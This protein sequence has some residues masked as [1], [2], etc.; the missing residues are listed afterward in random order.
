MM[1][2][3]IAGDLLPWSNNANLFKK[4]DAKTLFGN[5]VCQLFATAD[6]SILN[7]E[8]PLTDA[9][10]KQQKIGPVIKADK[11]TIKGLQALKVKAVALANNH[12]TDYLQKGID[13]TIAVLKSAGIDY[14][15]VI[16]TNNPN[17]C[18]YLSVMIGLKRVCIY[19]VSETF[20]NR[21]T[22][23][24]SGANVYDEWI[25]LNEIKELKQRH[26]FL[27]VIYHGGAE[28][29]QYPTPQT[30]TRFHRMANCGADFITAQHTHCIGCEEWY[31]GS[32]LLYGQGNF[33][34][35]KQSEGKMKTEGL[36]MELVFNDEGGV[37][38]KK[39]HVQ[40]TKQAC[41]SYSTDQTLSS[42]YERCK[43][44]DNSDLIIE[45]YKELKPD[46]IIESYLLAYKG[47]YYIWN[48]F[49]KFL[50]KRIWRNLF[51][52][53]SYSQIMRNLFVQTSDRACE[54]VYYIWQK[55]LSKN[56]KK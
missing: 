6:Y 22:N 9:T 8:G 33:L 11:E 15:G 28:Y 30:R 44:I 13:D 56:N 47:R 24:S 52:S 53:Y 23:N 4:G 48:K 14:V 38:I 35:A 51:E 32:Y 17:N 25:V 50:P 39:H 7:L 21:P 19:N 54:D 46:N 34:F 55:L 12:I 26:D 3:V 1:K 40:L 29:F 10:V 31:N 36:V 41:L 5:E 27:I 49:K 42:F 43:E 37:Q 45:K 16:T 18:K 2:I 20:F